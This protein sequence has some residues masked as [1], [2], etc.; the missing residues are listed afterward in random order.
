MPRTPD[1]IKSKVGA[2]R[3][4]ALQRIRHVLQD[5]LAGRVSDENAVLLIWAAM[6]D[7][8]LMD[9]PKEYYSGQKR[10]RAP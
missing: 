10:D 3:K 8:D 6:V 5:W 2:D 1:Q 4:A 7:N 9:R